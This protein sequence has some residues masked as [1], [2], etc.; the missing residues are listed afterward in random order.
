MNSHGDVDEFARS[1]YQNVYDAFNGEGC[2]E[3]QFEDCKEGSTFWQVLLTSYLPVMFLWL[4]RAMFGITML[5][6]TIVL[7]HLLRLL[8]GNVSDWVN[9]KTPTWI[10]TM[11][12]PLGGGNYHHAGKL[13]DNS[14]PPPALTGLALLTIFALVV[15]PDGYTWIVL[16]KSRYV[17][18]ASLCLLVRKIKALTHTVLILLLQRCVA[19]DT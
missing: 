17:M 14:W 15:H 10:N 13:T 1:D 5:V 19:V 16:R 7:G 3:N 6:R 8:C 9:E 18:L 2:G 4:R 12:Q 11:L